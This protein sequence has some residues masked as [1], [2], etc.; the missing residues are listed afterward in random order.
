MRKTQ[1]PHLPVIQIY[2]REKILKKAIWK[3]YALIPVR[4]K[5]ILHW[6]WF[7][8]LVSYEGSSKDLNFIFYLTLDGMYG[9]DVIQ[10]FYIFINPLFA[11]L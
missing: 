7:Q 4:N 1:K 3:S 11:K 9:S 8:K 5:Q 2:C 10:A 6:N